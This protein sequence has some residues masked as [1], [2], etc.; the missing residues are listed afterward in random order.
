MRFLLHD[1]Q[2]FLFD[3]SRPISSVTVCCTGTI[4]ISGKWNYL[5]VVKS[6]GIIRDISQ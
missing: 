1:C 5:N 6:T 3:L 4:S 2:V